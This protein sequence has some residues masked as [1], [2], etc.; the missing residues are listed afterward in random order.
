MHAHHVQQAQSTQPYKQAGIWLM[1]MS[2]PFSKQKHS[3]SQHARITMMP[4]QL[5]ND[6]KHD[7]DR[8]PQAA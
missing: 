1:L 7:C 3:T 5:Q 4:V 6:N 2:Q 8:F